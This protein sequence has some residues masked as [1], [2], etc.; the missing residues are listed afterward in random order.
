MDETLTGLLGEGRIPPLIAVGIDNAGRSGRAK[1]Y[2]PYPDEF[3][4]PPEP[5]PQGGAVR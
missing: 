1:E 2:L 4:D 5:S 3:L